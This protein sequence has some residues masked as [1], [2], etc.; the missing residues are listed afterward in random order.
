MTIF[1]ASLFA[2]IGFYNA[3]V[4]R[5]S[6]APA[7]LF[8]WL[9]SAVLFGLAVSGDAFLP[10]SA[11]TLVLLMVAV[12]A[13]SAGGV[14]ALAQTR[15]HREKRA[16]PAPWRPLSKR[17]DTLI[18]T[19]LA[20]LLLAL[21]L[22]GLFL[23]RLAAESSSP[24]FWMAVRLRTSADVDAV[25]LGPFAYIGAFST[26][27]AFAALLQTL[28]EHRGAW[29]AACAVLVALA[30][31]LG[32]VA[33]TGPLFL[34]VGLAGVAWA[35]T[36]RLGGRSAVLGFCAASMVFGGVAI[37]LHKG[38]DADSSLS[39]SASDLFINARTYLLGGTVALDQYVRG[40]VHLPAGM[41]TLRFFAILGNAVGARIP[42]PDIVLDYVDTPEPTNVY[43]MFFPY[44][45]DFGWAGIVICVGVL[46]W[47]GTTLYNGCRRHIPHCYLL[48]AL[49][50]ACLVLGIANDQYFSALSLWLQLT[51][52][53]F[54]LF[55]RARSD[56]RAGA[57][58]I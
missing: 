31:Q 4:A 13:F 12:L 14:V 44:Y 41:R 16:L 8:A 52:F 21:P 57:V 7:A 51:L 11:E 45:A 50:V 1:A 29:R 56:V 27:L 43:T 18:T 36:G 5:S 22:Y 2:G 9:W 40:L 23:R 20:L 49:F 32:T 33:R 26:F 17:A 37:V 24:E 48:Y 34:I 6:A 38:T 10:L 3:R 42:V 39:Q 54:I 35:V 53:T 55:R 28:Q 47:L 15:L 58:T 46:G 30:F 19:G 25:G